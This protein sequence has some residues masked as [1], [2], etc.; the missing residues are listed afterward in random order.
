MAEKASSIGVL[1]I[2]LYV[3]L[4]HHFISFEYIQKDTAPPLLNANESFYTRCVY[5]PVSQPMLLNI[6]W[7]MVFYSLPFSMCVCV[8]L[9]LTLFLSFILLDFFFLSFFCFACRGPEC[10]TCSHQNTIDKGLGKS[11][12]TQCDNYLKE[13]PPSHS[14]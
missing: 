7:L 4:W 9:Y 8:Y 2:P 14:F 1:L 10:V 12:P 13:V 5:A 6:S 11:L 3:N